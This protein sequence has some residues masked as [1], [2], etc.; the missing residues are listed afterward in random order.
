MGFEDL[1][2][3]R[4]TD[5]AKTTDFAILDCSPSLG[6]LTMNALRASDLVMVPV[7]CEA[8]SAQG[9]ESLLELVTLMRRRS[10]DLRLHVLPTLYDKRNSICRE[11]LTGLKRS[12][13]QRMSDVVV[14]ID[15]KVRDSQARRT[16]LCIY[17]PASRANKAYRL[18][19]HEVEQLAVRRAPARAA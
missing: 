10:P 12:F 14:G 1:L 7:Q 11:V 16:P 8:F 3:G 2:K 4:L 19:A 18:L 5:L 13:A 17:E 9:V 6:A 15:T